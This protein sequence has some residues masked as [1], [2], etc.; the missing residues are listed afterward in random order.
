[1]WKSSFHSVNKLGETCGKLFSFMIKWKNKLSKEEDMIDKQELF[2][3]RFL[4]LAQKEIAPTTYEVFILDAKLIKVEHKIAHISLLKMKMDYWQEHIHPVILP[5]ILAAGFEIYNDAISIDYRVEDRTSYEEFIDNSVTPLIKEPLPKEPVSSNINPKYHFDNF[6]LGKGN[7]MAYSAAINVAETTGT[8]Y[9]PLFIWGGPGLGKTHLLNAIGNEAMARDPRTRVKYVTTEEF[10]NEFIANIR[11]G[12][13]EELKEK[14]RTLDYLLIDDVQSLAGKDGTQEELRNT[15]DA[16]L[17]NDKQIV[18]TSDRAPEQLEGLEDRL[19][20]RFGWGTS[21]HITP[22]DYETRFAIIQ[23]KTESFHL[24][25][26]RESI[27]YLAN[28]FTSNVREIEGA[29]NNIKLVATSKGTDTVSIDLIAEALRAIKP[30]DIKMTVIPIETIKEET[31]KF[32]GVTVKD[33]NSTKRQQSIALARQIA[34]YLTRELTDYS[35][36]KIGKEFGG[37]DHSTV[38]HSYRKIEEMIKTDKNLK[39]EIN[40]I[41]AKLT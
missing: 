38:L 27:E 28:Q 36:P 8:M 23:K 12:K 1:M 25:F 10:V 11:T 33:I 15:F 13:M 3:A 21:T 19:V 41:I 32:Y 39:T 37:R 26:P 14:Y 16:L 40:T 20:S 9:N 22:P 17:N 34:M 18:L 2:W 6:I 30:S 5:L 7:Q 31:G 29:L 4:E 24:N 35:L